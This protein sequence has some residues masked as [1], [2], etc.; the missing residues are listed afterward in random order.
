MACLC[1]LR[2]VFRIRCLGEMHASQ[3]GENLWFSI[4]DDQMK[5]GMVED[6]KKRY[7]RKKGTGVL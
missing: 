3:G 5:V 2:Y 1:S 6:L 7:L 4:E